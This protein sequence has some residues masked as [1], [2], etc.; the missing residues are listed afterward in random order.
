MAPVKGTATY[1][2]VENV[3]PPTTVCVGINQIDISIDGKPVDLSEMSDVAPTYIKKGKTIKEIQ[4]TLSGRLDKTGNGQTSL[5][6]NITADT[7]I[8]IK[9]WYGAATFLFS[10]NVDNVDMKDSLEDYIT[11]TY[12]L[13]NEGTIAVTLA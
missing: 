3:N 1:C 5:W 12:T 7:V 10:C 9:V 6:S 2:K 11:V 8:Y 13:S 4:C